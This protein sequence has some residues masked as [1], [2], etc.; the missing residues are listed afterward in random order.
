M[1]A[2]SFLAT[3]L[4]AFLLLAAC[5][6][7]P[8]HAPAEPV[9]TA[10]LPTGTPAE[11]SSLWHAAKRT[12]DQRCV[13]CHGCYDS[14]C[15]LALSSFDGLERGA[16]KQK[17]Y[18]SSRLLAAPPTRL[19]V[20]AYDVD[21]WRAKDFY[22]VLPEGARSDPRV[23]LL[24]GMLE[25]KRAHPL[26]LTRGALPKEFEIGLDREEQC[27]MPDEFD[28]YK[29]DHPS[30]GM[31]Y[32]LP[33][34]AE[35]DHH[36]LVSWV[37][38]GT[39]HEE[40]APLAPAIH[41]SIERWEAF[42]NHSGIKEQ[43]V[44]RYLYE[45]LFLASIYFEGVDEH[46]FFRMVRSSTPPG[47]PVVEVATRRPFDDPG[48]QPF[49]Y[50]LLRR[51][52]TVLSKTHMPYALSDKRLSRYRELFIEPSYIVE[53]TPDYEPSRTANPFAT[54][55]SLPVNARYR[56]MLEEA[57]FTLSGFIKGPVCRGQVALDVIDDRFW[58]AFVHPDS[59]AV[60]REAELL[61]G[62][63][64]DL[65]M[66]AE[67]GSNGLVVTWRKYANRERRY[68]A[69]K[70]TWLSELTEGATEVTEQQLWDGDGTNPNAALTV[71]R[72]FDSA[73]VVKGFVGGDPKTAW[74]VGY[75]LLERIHY[76]LVAGFD[77]FG[78]VGHQLHSRLYMDFLRMEAEFNFLSL[79]P[80]SR[81][82]VLMESWYRDTDDEVKDQVYG[83]YA[84]FDRETG[85]AYK[86]QAP[87]HELFALM[88]KRV[89]KV[90]DRHRG[91]GEEPDAQLRKALTPV[92]LLAGEAAT[93]MPETS[94][95]EVRG[96]DGTHKYFSI[97]R[98]SAHTN[99]AHL[100]N[101]ADRRRPLEDQTTL[102]RGF[103]GAYPNAM[104]S[105]DEQ[106]VPAFVASMSRL[107]SSAA[108][109]SLRER[110]GV[111]RTDARFWAY[112][113][114]IHAAYQELSPL[115]A[116]LFDYNRLDGR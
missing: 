77:V 19:H 87:E 55:A 65:A 53:T 8:Q 38:A 86:T 89:S 114:R 54:F 12:F 25:L 115:E 18:D 45:H 10:P 74:V 110:F 37:Q 61:A 49:Y 33:A 94:F 71:L 22:P 79:L 109:D 4:L 59:P 76:L 58:I 48:I 108:Y 26:P 1:P 9:T 99:V 44:S 83:K 42:F 36:A 102:L 82:R 34:L 32:A 104:F 88:T 101:E 52:D 66:P 70:S 2:Q 78:N 15:Q 51:V 103:V 6:P 107:D 63:A 5:S 43:L 17:V 27:P 46:V 56:F 72:H 3:G 60:Q 68:V 13:V 57:H 100:F 80:R 84:H 73:S 91:L 90:L 14:P 40:P 85:I 105:V 69:A 20:D 47:K 39:P 16:T 95:L 30:W 50:R 21:G 41:E 81:R 7:K 28:R 23:A 67:Q 35:P 24:T 93:L 106:D 97:L 92:A 113:D 62:E 11:Q 75:A 98:D 111:R 112:S 31:P 96:R 29:K 116:G 64:E